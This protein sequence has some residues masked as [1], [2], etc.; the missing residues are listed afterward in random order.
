[1]RW[2]VES[3]FNC[4]YL[5]NRIRWIVNRVPVETRHFILDASASNLLDSTGAVALSEIAADLA[6]RDITFSI[7]ELHH[8]PRIL[9]ERAGFFDQIG[10]DHVFEQLEHALDAVAL[11]AE[12]G[13]IESKRQE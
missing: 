8:R 2:V 3:T 5:R 12:T 4:D 13:D 10:R 6:R 9:L 7:A 11:E 1:M